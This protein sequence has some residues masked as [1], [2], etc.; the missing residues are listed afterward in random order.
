[1]LIIESGES[2]LGGIN[3]S[4]DGERFYVVSQVQVVIPAPANK[5]V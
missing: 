1:M 3:I 5:T 2:G 4:S